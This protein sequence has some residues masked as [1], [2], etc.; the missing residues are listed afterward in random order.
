MDYGNAI[1]EALSNSAHDQNNGLNT[2]ELAILL[3]VRSRNISGDVANLKKEGKI[4]ECELRKGDL[5]P[6]YRLSN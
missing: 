4:I 1:L 2:V 6:R 5:I 3:H